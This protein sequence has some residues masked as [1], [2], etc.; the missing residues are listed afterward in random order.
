MFAFLKTLLWWR[1]SQPKLLAASG[2]TRRTFFGGIGA[3]LGSLLIPGFRKRDP[4]SE[5]LRTA[6]GRS[7]LAMAMAF[8]L[9]QK[10]D[11]NRLSR[12]AFSVESLP[13]PSRQV[14]EKDED[15]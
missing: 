3:T 14:Y 2:V 15:A 4:I 5:Y 11:Y 9:R 10:L 12:Q 13:T 1:K 7:K 8:P 6:E